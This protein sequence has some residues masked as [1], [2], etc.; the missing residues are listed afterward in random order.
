MTEQPTSNSGE[1]ENQPTYNLESVIEDFKKVI[2]DPAGFYRAMPTDGGF[3]NPL[4]FIVV[5]AAVSGVLMA[6]LSLVGLGAGSSMMGGTGFMMIIMLPIGAAIGSFIAAGLLFVLWKLM[7]S[8]KNYETAYRCIAFATAIMPITTVLSIIPY[9]G[10]IVKNLW[11][12]FLLFTASTEV[13]AIKQQTAKIVFAVLAAITVLVGV[14]SEYKMRQF[15]SHFEKVFEQAKANP[16]IGGVFKG[17]E[18]MEDM[19]PEEAGKKMGELLKGMEEFGK[20]MEETIKAD[21][22]QEKD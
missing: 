14:N 9:L 2:T 3:V 12:T 20:G 15:Q 7:G 13:H 18:N 21:D 17:L 16:N 22:E 19:T 8:T 1:P 10:T 5:M 6:I 4:I 11:G